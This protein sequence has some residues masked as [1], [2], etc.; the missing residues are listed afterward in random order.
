MRNILMYSVKIKINE[1]FIQAKAFVKFSDAKKYAS[2][3]QEFQIIRKKCIT[4]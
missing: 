3:F 1:K 4:I 2:D